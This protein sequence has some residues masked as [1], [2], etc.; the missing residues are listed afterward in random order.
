MLKKAPG[1]KT[2]F[3]KD[4]LEKLLGIENLSVTTKEE[5]D[6]KASFVVTDKFSIPNSFSRMSLIKAV[7]SPGAFLSISV[8]EEKKFKKKNYMNCGVKES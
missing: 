5:Q 2:A 3:I 7:L 4:I 6:S 8:L 1:D